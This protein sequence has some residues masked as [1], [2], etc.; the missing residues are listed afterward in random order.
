MRA[1]ALLLT[2]VVAAM[3]AGE[4]HAAPGR[5]PRNREPGLG[6]SLGMDPGQLG[7]SG[8]SGKTGQQSQQGTQRGQQG[9]DDSL[10]ED[11]NRE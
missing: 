9:S 10:D 2:V 3:A 4:G 11:F 8:Q 7:Q 5:E 6:R 1:G